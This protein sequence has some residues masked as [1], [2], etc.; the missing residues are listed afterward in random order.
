MNNLDKQLNKITSR[1]DVEEFNRNA[2]EVFENEVVP[3]IKR[4]K[5]DN[6]T[7]VEWLD[8]QLQIMDSK[9]FNNLIQIEM[10]RDNYKQI[11]EQAKEMEKQQI[12]DFGYDIA[13]DLAWGKYRDKKAMEERYNEYLTYNEEEE[14]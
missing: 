3:Q 1:I 12:V 10:G 6:M 9:S 5:E 4:A 2:K 8:K 11:I 13:E 7:A 14:E